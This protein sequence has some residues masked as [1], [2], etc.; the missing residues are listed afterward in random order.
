VYQLNNRGC[1]VRRFA[2]HSPDD[3]NRGLAMRAF[4]VLPLVFLALAGCATPLP[5]KDDFGASALVAVGDIPP[6]FAEFN[7]FDPATNGMIA[8]QLC[9]TPLQRLNDNALEAAPGRLDQLVA[10]CR[11]HVPFFGS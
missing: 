10:R 4:L 7:R 8:N 2:A 11:T 6:G 1:A 9:A 3:C 5:A